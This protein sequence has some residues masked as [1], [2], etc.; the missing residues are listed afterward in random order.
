M[1]N[2]NTTISGILT[3]VVALLSAAQAVFD[4]DPTTEP[5]WAIVLGAFT[6]ALGLMFSKDSKPTP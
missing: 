1:K 3:F 5:Q 2:P 4:G 6:T